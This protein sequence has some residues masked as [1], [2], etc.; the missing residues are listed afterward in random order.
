MGDDPV[1]SPMLCKKHSARSGVNIQGRG[2][3]VLPKAV[4]LPEVG[5]KY[6]MDGAGDDGFGG[7]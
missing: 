6:W 5:E 4:Q 7:S 2:C 3:L 1:F